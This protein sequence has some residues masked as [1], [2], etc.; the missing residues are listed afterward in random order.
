L[1]NEIEKQY[2][3]TLVSLATPLSE[4]EL[5]EIEDGSYVP[6][7][8]TGLSKDRYWALYRDNS[9]FQAIVSLGF[10]V[11]IENFSNAPK[12]QDLLTKMSASDHWAHPN[13]YML[14][15]LVDEDF[16]EWWGSTFSDPAFYFLR[17]VEGY[18][19][20]DGDQAVE[21][22]ESE[23]FQVMTQEFFEQVQRNVF[24]ALEGARF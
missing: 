17:D 20:E 6:E 8:G 14:S 11:F 2:A 15:F 23:I 16:S 24:T 5:K 1:L 12:F 22:I 21:E 19:M 18:R 4:M 13:W 7:D 10:G 3:T 9:Q